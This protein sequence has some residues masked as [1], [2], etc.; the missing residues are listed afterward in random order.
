VRTQ[1]ATRHTAQAAAPVPS[2]AVTRNQRILDNMP[3]VKRL[4]R[5]V[6]AR[7][8]SRV[9]LDDLVGAGMLGLVLAADRFDGVRGVPFETF[10]RW[11]IHGALLDFLRGEDPLTREARRRLRESQ[12][13]GTEGGEPQFLDVDAIADRLSLDTPQ[14]YD[15]T[16]AL[17]RI[18]LRKIVGALPENDRKL[19]EL[20][21]GEEQTLR[22]VGAV[23]GVTESRICQRLSGILSRVR[24]SLK[25]G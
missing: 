11:R 8:P 25:A 1:L 21:Y 22:E 19:L 23:L 5:M 14:A 2:A 9:S 4:A 7:V 12:R 3:L 10:A 24:T 20:Y 18:R 16:D 15:A 17:A 13:S 6:A